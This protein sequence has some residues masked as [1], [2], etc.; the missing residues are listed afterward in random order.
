MLLVGFNENIFNKNAEL[1]LDHIKIINVED[2]KSV[3]NYPFNLL[4]Y[5]KMNIDT[6]DILYIDYFDTLIKFLNVIKVQFSFIYSDNMVIND[7]IRKS[8]ISKFILTENFT[9]NDFLS[10]Y[11]WYKKQNSSLNII[12]NNELHKT[13]TLEDLV[14]GNDSLTDLDVQDLKELQ[15]KLKMGVLLQAKSML[16]RVLQLTGILDKLY[17]ELLDRIDSSIKTTDTAS[18]MYTTDYISKALKDTNEFIVS[19]V[20]NEK[21]QNFFI[22]DNSTVINTGN[23]TFDIDKRERI[24]K[25]AEIIL[26]NYE[27]VADGKPELLVDPNSIEDNKQE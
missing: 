26:N 22:I 3:S 2:Y 8:D 15:N 7:Y 13:K 27:S 16:K 25:A 4:D 14:N 21:I 12:S 11:S 18:L 1:Y 19:L 10:Q 23:D 20:N 5:I 17:D 24:R 9:I 6:Y